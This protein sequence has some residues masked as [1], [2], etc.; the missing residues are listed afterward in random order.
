MGR[1]AKFTKEDFQKYFPKRCFGKYQ[2]LEFRL[3]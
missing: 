1:F 3:T 2:S